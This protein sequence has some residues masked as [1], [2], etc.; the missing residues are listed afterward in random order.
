ML[1][2]PPH[3]SLTLVKWKGP[4]LLGWDSGQGQIKKPK[5]FCQ[6]CL[7]LIIRSISVRRSSTILRQDSC[8]QCRNKR[9]T[10]ALMDLDLTISQEHLGVQATSSQ[11]HPSGLP[12]HP[13]AQ[14][15]EPTRSA[16]LQGEMFQ[17]S[18]EIQI[19]ITGDWRACS[20]DGNLC[21]LL[22]LGRP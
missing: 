18:L 5:Q 6:V 3:P 19:L 11:G 17:F 20:S 2:S 8:L 12:R 22:H 7:I 9:K 16:L 10:Y 4:L 21:S 13:S 1:A 15:Q 14:R